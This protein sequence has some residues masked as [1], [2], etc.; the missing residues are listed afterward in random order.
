MSEAEFNRPEIDFG[1]LPESVFM[2]ERAD[3]LCQ[4]PTGSEVNLEESFLFHQAL[5]DHKI[6]SKKLQ[7]AKKE[8]GRSFNHVQAYRWLKT[9]SNC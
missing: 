8:G 7:D 3:V 1:K 9:I 4:W 2:Q 6:F 5:P